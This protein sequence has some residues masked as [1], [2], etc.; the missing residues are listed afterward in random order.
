MAYKLGLDDY[1]LQLERLK[2]S[3]LDAV[4]HWGDAREGAVILNQMRSMGMNQPFFASDRAV[5]GEFVKL[6]G[7]NA[8]GVVCGYPWNPNR[9]DP[10]LAS[11]RAAFHKRFG[12]EP[13]TYAAHAYDGMNMV[14]WAIQVAGL[15]RAKIR[16]MIAYRPKPWPGVTGDIPLSAALDD[17]GDVFLARFEE[18][19]WKYHSREELEIP[20]G[21]IP[22]RDR[23]TR[24]SLTSSSE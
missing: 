5:S 20:R 22:A 9:T 6:A 21:Y 3:N 4:V 1:S 2:A 14:L 24:S 16:D 7:G 12:D 8:E 13:D 10:K 11:F 18:G 23:V 17:L 15:N 19:A